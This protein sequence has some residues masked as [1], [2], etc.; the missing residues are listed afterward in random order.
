M[1]AEKTTPP[2]KVGN[3]DVLSDLCDLL[4]E[5]GMVLVFW[6]CPNGCRGRVIWNDLKT[7]ATCQ[8]C[9][10]RKSDNDRTE[11]LT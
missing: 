8:V 7:D 10:C 6:V 5:C 9:G 2:L 3:G 11:R 4:T 1:E